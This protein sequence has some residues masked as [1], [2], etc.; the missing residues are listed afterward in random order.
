VALLTAVVRSP[1][2]PITR[3]PDYVTGLPLLVTKVHWTVATYFQQSS[4]NIVVTAGAS[5]A[6]VASFDF[7]P[8]ALF[9]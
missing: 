9:G 1:D 6:G 5:G 2:D 7:P 8:A 4:S 3:S